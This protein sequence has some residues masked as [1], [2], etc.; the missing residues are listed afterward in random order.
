M[1]GLRVDTRDRSQWFGDWLSCD[2]AHEL[3]ASVSAILSAEVSVLLKV[4]RAAPTECCTFLLGKRTTA[5]RCAWS[6]FQPA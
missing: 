1:Y 6:P 2:D 3:A 4:D 5:C